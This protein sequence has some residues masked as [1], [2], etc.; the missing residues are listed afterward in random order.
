MAPPL[1]EHVGDGVG[2]FLERTHIDDMEWLQL[3]GQ[4][5]MTVAV[6]FRWPKQESPLV[7]D[8]I[9][10]ST[11]TRSYTQQT[12]HELPVGASLYS[13]GLG[14]QRLVRSPGGSRAYQYGIEGFGTWTAWQGQPVLP[15]REWLHLADAIERAWTN[16]S[17][18]A[19]VMRAPTLPG[20]LFGA[21]EL[22]SSDC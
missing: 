18:C 21:R 6:G 10:S 15:R 1:Y 8:F 9:R 11:L 7:I 2:L 13:E 14:M 5:Q 19:A 17:M 20:V 12:T 3:R 4:A 16:L 22:C